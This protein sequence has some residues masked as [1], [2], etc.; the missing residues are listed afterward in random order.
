M[1]KA[2]CLLLL[3]LGAV[4]GQASDLESC[5]LELQRLQKEASRIHTDTNC[6]S[7]AAE[8]DL[9]LMSTAVLGL[10]D[11]LAKM[12]KILQV[13][14]K[15]EKIAGVAHAVADSFDLQT[16]HFSMD[17]QT[18]DL[19]YKILEAISALTELTNS[20]MSKTLQRQGKI[21]TEVSELASSKNSKEIKM[22]N[23]CEGYKAQAVN[24]GNMCLS[25][26]HA[27]NLSMV[28]TTVL[29]GMCQALKDDGGCSFNECVGVLFPLWFSCVLITSVIILALVIYLIWKIQNQ[30]ATKSVDL[31]EEKGAATERGVLSA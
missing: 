6:L 29:K 13:I 4:L 16:A 8:S 17:N 15:G 3:Q 28:N 14:A 18:S 12:D 21:L 30:L 9:R 1:F 2:V 11:S 19:A 27:Q 10:Q 22:F 31:L 26:T 25:W 24:C 7:R 20:K 23:E 5:H